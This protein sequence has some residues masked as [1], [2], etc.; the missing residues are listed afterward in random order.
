M[1]VENG[2]TEE[3]LGAP[4]VIA[5]G[6]WGGD[7]VKVDV[8]G[9]L[10]K[11]T[12]VARAF[13]EADAMIVATH[14]K[15]GVVMG[16]SGSL[17]NIGVGCVSKA[18]KWSSHAKS[19]PR[20]VEERCDGCG[21]CLKYCFTEAIRIEAYKADINQERC[22]GCRHCIDVCPKE[23]VAIEFTRFPEIAIR[24]VD[25]ASAVIKNIGFKRIG[26]FNFLLDITPRCDCNPFSDLPIVPDIGIL[27]SKDPVAI[28]KA[29]ADLVN[30][31]PGIPGSAIDEVGAMSPGLDKFT[32][33]NKMD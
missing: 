17:K 16:F 1:A 25:A 27:A 4:I 2:F 26:Y 7:D 21:S 28:D 5:D 11:E 10:L 3:T 31:S 8:D 22:V 6:E 14:F 23:A 20:I 12:Y 15:V 24:I 33:L 9:N 32:P 30:A 13:A 18:G 19:K 29:S